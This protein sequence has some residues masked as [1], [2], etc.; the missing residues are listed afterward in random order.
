MLDGERI[1]SSG[2]GARRWRCGDFERARRWLVGRGRCAAGEAGQAP[3]RDLGFPTANLSLERGARR[4][5][6]FAVRVHGVGSARC[7]AS[8]VSAPAHGPRRRDAAGGDLFDFCEDLYGR[9]IEVEFVAK[10]RDEHASRRS[11]R[12]RRRCGAMQ[13]RP[14]RI[15]NG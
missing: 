15:L 6:D 5:R 1:S 3:G 14:R 11:R 12:S 4:R 8:P 10:L 2:V 9:E 7:R 13:R